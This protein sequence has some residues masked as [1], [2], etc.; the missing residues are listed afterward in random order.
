MSRIT[1]LII[2]SGSSA[3]SIRSLRFAR[4]SVATRSSTAIAVLP[5][6][7]ARGVPPHAHC[8]LLAT[9]LGQ[10][11]RSA[12][13]PATSA[14]QLDSGS[15]I[16]PRRLVSNLPHLREQLVHRHAGER[17]EERRHLRGDLRDV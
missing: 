3:R 13:G 15:L 11:A 10:S 5:F 17:L 14:F 16:L 8:A 4:T 6:F 1:C 9:D 7:S 2:F 12:R